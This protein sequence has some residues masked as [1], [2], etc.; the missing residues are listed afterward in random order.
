M[1]ASISSPARRY[2][3]LQHKLRGLFNLGLSDTETFQRDWAETE[4]LK[5][6]NGGLPPVAERTAWPAFPS[7]EPVRTS[8]AEWRAS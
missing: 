8:L 7:V 4:A 5:N 2:A 6:A 3:H 1:N